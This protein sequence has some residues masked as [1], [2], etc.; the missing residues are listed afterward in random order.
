MFL[1]LFYNL[2]MK[3]AIQFIQNTYLLRQMNFKKNQRKAYKIFLK[4]IAQLFRRISFNLEGSYLNLESV[5]FSFK[6][7]MHGILSSLVRKVS[8]L[9]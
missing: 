1:Q 4:K 7:V 8:N 5:M 9:I 3:S 6:W 2:Q